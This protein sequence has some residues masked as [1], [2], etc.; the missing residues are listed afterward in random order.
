MNRPRATTAHDEAQR[1]VWVLTVICFSALTFLSVLF[2]LTVAIQ[3]AQSAVVTPAPTYPVDDFRMVQWC[4]SGAAVYAS[5]DGQLWTWLE[6]WTAVKPGYST[7]EFCDAPSL[8][9]R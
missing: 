9:L 6:R 3:P 8:Q 1:L 7:A 2:V 4:P 5:P